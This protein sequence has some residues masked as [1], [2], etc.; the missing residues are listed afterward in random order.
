MY[1]IHN[2][3][4]LIHK[5]LVIEFLF[6]WTV[7]PVFFCHIVTYLSLY[8][9]FD[10]SFPR[11]YFDLQFLKNCVLSALLTN[12]SAWFKP[13]PESFWV[14]CARFP[15]MWL[16]LLFQLI[17]IMLLTSQLSVKIYSL[18]K[19]QHFNSWYYERK[20]L[21]DIYRQVNTE[22]YTER[23]LCLYSTFDPFVDALLKILKLLYKA[24]VSCFFP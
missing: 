13:F 21:H 14:L 5:V 24:E 20:V 16:H 18:R 6:W 17:D 7:C 22:I 11:V 23:D 12:W 9:H 10:I 19:H 8:C 3:V 4:L 1:Q 15:T 2:E